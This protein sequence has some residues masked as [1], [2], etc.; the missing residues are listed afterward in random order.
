LIGAALT[1][2]TPDLAGAFA[3]TR[4]FCAFATVGAAF[5]ALRA[6]EFCCSF[7]AFS[8][9]STSFFAIAFASLFTLLFAFSFSSFAFLRAFAAY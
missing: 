6:I 5:F 8:A 9:A 3:F 4:A 1:H 7:D 2:F